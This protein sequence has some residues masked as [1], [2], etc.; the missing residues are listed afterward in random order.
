MRKGSILYIQA[1]LHRMMKPAFFFFLHCTMPCFKM[2]LFIPANINWY[3]LLLPQE[4]PSANGSL[5]R[6]CFVHKQGARLRSG[7]AQQ[8]PSTSKG[9]MDFQVPLL[10]EISFIWPLKSRFQLAGKVSLQRQY[11]LAPATISP[12]KQSWKLKCVLKLNTIDSKIW[13]STSV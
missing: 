10:P 12:P 6:S 1:L 4:V 11:I 2:Y 13:Y 3:L 7:K 9:C 8:S 5:F